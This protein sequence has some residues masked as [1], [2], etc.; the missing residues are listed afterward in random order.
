MTPAPRHDARPGA[1][2]RAGRAGAHAARVIV[3]SML[4][5]STAPWRPG[6]DPAA[7]HHPA[8][9]G[10]TASADGGAGEPRRVVVV[11]GGIAGI[12]AAVGL[13]ERGVE[14]T[15]VEAE[16]S[17]GGRVRS[18][19]VDVPGGGP[20]TMGRGFHA[21]FRQYY[22]LRAL[23]RRVDP[24]LA[25]LR[26]VDD[27]PLVHADGTRDSFTGIPTRPPFNFLGFVVKSPSFGARDLLRVDLE[28]ALDLLDVDFPRTYARYDGISAARALDELRFPARMRSLA[29]EVF[30]RSFFADPRDFSAGELVA[31]FHMYFLGS[32]EGLLFDVSRDDFDATWWRPLRRYLEGLGAEV[33]PGERVTAVEVADGGA[34]AGDVRVATDAGA[35]LSAEAVVLA[36]SRDAL[37]HLVG[38]STIGDATWRDRLLGQRMAPRF[39]VWRLWFDR[40]VTTPCAPFVGTA[41]FGLCDNL[42]LVHEL[43]EGA[44]RW[45]ERRGGSVVELHAYAVPDDVDDDAAFAD[46]HAQLARLLPEFAGVDPVHEERLV[47]A[48]CPLAGTDEWAS[49]PGV[50]TP[51]PRVVLAGDGI[52]CELPVALMERA[53]ATGFQAA[54]ALLASWRLPGHDVWSVPTRARFPRAIAMGRRAAALRPAVLRAS[55]GASSAPERGR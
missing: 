1:T 26:P 45:A 19:P 32:G 37:Q 2:R 46:L 16:S 53:A 27:Y 28:R 34:G 49:R 11:G 22:T 6:Q 10:S 23:L 14:V 47:A 36:P 9:A 8:P 55:A 44:R 51:D 41:A 52:R 35:V 29:L 4:G 38:A 20:Q 43:E 15:L 24:A 50:V 21:F 25:G 30:A 18:W 42:S 17:L 5:G 13:A 33:R 54:N 31:M 12:S 40:P 39:V 3:G 7:Q 48:D